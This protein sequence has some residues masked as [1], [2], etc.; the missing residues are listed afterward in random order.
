MIGIM[1]L[2]YLWLQGTLVKFCRG[3]IRICNRLIKQ[4]PKC[5][6]QNGMQEGDASP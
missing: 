2:L 5:Q 4:V 3:M 6:C 1:G